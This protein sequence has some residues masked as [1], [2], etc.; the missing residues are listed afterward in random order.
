MPTIVKENFSGGINQFVDESKLDLSTQQYC[1]TNG[2]TR[3]GVLGPINAPLDIT[4]SL[5]NSGTIQGLYAAGNILITFIGGRAY[6]ADRAELSWKQIDGF[7]MSDLVD[8]IYLDLIPASSINFVRKL[9]YEEE[10]Q[11]G[12]RLSTQAI[13]PSPRAAIVMDGISQP[14][15]IFPD[16]TAR[17]T[18]DYT[19]WT[20]ENP[21][22]VPIATM[23]MYHPDGI[24]YCVGKDTNGD[25]TQ[26]FRSVSGMP[27]N[28]MVPI[29]PDGDKI[30]S[31]E[32][33]GGAQQVAHRIDYEPVSCLR[34][35]PAAEGAFLGTTT[36]NAYLIHPDGYTKTI[37]GEP[38]FSNQWLFDVG[39][40]NNESVV[41]IR[42]D[43]ALIHYR[44]IRSFNGTAEFKVQ[45]KNDP[46]S[47]PITDLLEG[48]TQTTVAATNF[49]NYTIFS[50]TTKYGPA[51]LW[52]D[53]LTRAFTSI[54][55]Y[56]GVGLVKQ[57]AVVQ[58]AE[59]MELYF[60]TEDNKLYKALAGEAIL[61]CSTYF[62]ALIPN[63][64]ME[65]RITSVALTFSSCTEAGHVQCNVYHD[66]VISRTQ[67][68]DIEAIDTTESLYEPVPFVPQREDDTHEVVFDFSDE[69]EYSVKCGIQV[70]WNA[71]M[72]LTKIEIKTDE[73][74]T[75]VDP[76]LPQILI[77]SNPDKLLFIG[78]D[79][80]DTVLRSQ[81]FD[82]MMSE[83]VDLYVGTGD[84]QYNADAENS[85][86]KYWR[87]K[88][89]E[90]KFIA[91]PGNHDQ[92][93]NACRDFREFMRMQPSRY[94]KH[95][96]RNTAL[97]MINDGIKTNGTIIEPD[98]I[99]ASPIAN[100]TQFR[101]LQAELASATEPHKLVVWHKPPYTA[102]YNKGGGSTTMRDVPLHNWG[103]SAL[104]CGDTHALERVYKRGFDYFITGGGGA[105]LYDK[106]DL[107]CPESYFYAKQYGYLLAQCWP[108]TVEFTFKSY[109]GV[110]LDQWTISI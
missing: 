81:I 18:N 76:R 110:I 45:G 48:I 42:G 53:T 7:Q 86:Y 4:S 74:S 55:I 33:E 36:K 62:G 50:L 9:A 99:D 27:L 109:L 16:G 58:T 43:T 92:D 82:A 100:A 44:G 95:S 66:R 64:G 108:I 106:D 21:E 97:F 8:R 52:Y 59:A 34:R 23:P 94:F 84:H 29:T 67:V 101:W 49:D 41:D 98:S 107:L 3:R 30:S 37:Y 15:V 51:L 56:K 90:G 80:V 2:R 1:I 60:Y 25:L 87:F 10:A 72:N 75:L 88:R 32:A 69:T 54:D 70:V 46:F 24:L 19:Q 20:K 40:L 26:I 104:I 103:A 5:E 73:K 79:G 89:D 12:V 77:P 91:V 31:A 68:R 93:F 57:F 65:H 39:A 102:A 28:F 63:V 85:F 22:Y 61:P 38:T 14:W 71:R 35:I 105:A 13:A 6:Y 17:V 47:I 78:D 11:A 96:L 83:D